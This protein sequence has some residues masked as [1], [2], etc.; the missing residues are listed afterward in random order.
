MGHRVK[1][2]GKNSEKG[3]IMFGGSCG[4][5]FLQSIAGRRRL[6]CIHER[7]PKNWE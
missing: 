3:D 6:P 1:K 5:R 4:D 2:G 7:N